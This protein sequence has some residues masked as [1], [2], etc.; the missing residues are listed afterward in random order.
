MPGGSYTNLNEGD[1]LTHEMGHYLGLLHT[2]SSSS[3]Q[4]SVDSDDQ[5]DDTPLESTPNY[6][7]SE[8][9]T[10]KNDEGSDPIWS[11]M[12]YTKDACMTRF[13][14]GQVCWSQSHSLCSL[15]STLF[16]SFYYALP[17]F[18]G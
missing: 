18:N 5:V 14:P 3:G 12:D 4:C 7:C 10:C 17:F 9:D 6:G 16:S 8:R 2:F 15:S 11:F 13:S 1:T